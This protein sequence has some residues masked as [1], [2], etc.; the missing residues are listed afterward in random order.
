M[1]PTART[2]QFFEKQGA[3]VAIIEKWL[4]VPNLPGGGV[5]KD[6]W[7]ADMLVRQG[8]LLM[9]IQATSGSNHSS[10]VE[11]CLA[12]PDILNWLHCG[13]NFYVYSWRP[14]V[15]YNKDGRKS[16]LPQMTA[17]ITQLVENK[18]GKV[19]VL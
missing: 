5:R 17:R 18:N 14:L 13:V 10:H 2:K 8:S 3:K 7:G 9:A 12:N 15:K 1:S 19:A 16:K 4:Q 11:K 6:T